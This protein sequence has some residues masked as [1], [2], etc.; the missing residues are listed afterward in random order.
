MNES[1]L[2]QLTLI[3]V[4]AVGGTAIAGR[5]G[6]PSI[7]LLLPLGF[8]F[9]AG[10][11]LLDPDELFGDLLTPLVSLSVAVIL[12]DGGLGLRLARVSAGARRAVVGLL[13]VGVAVTW[14][15]GTLGAMALFDIRR[16]LAIL[17]G[18]ILI[19]SGPTVVLPIL[20]IARPRGRVAAVTRWEGILV[21]PIGAIIAVVTFHVISSGGPN[22]RGEGIKDFA[23]TVGLGVVAG[24]VGATILFKL[25]KFAGLAPHAE[26]GVTLG[27]VLATFAVPD[28]ILED[29][30][31]LSVVI[32]GIFIAN[33][34]RVPVEHI[35]EFKEIVGGLLTGVL[36]IVLSAR[37]PA[38]SLADHLVPALVLTA[39]LVVLARPLAV[40]AA[41]ARTTLAARERAFLA[42]MAPRG[43]VVASVSSI[44]ALQL[45]AQGVPGADDLVPITFIVIVATTALYGLTAR[46]VAVLLGV[47]EPD[48]EPDTTT[49]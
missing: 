49:T 39:I 40:A 1:D 27:I 34:K 33:Q 4:L 18:A 19:M 26:V 35:T 20:S 43:I 15:A 11:G 37:I 28:A 21:D 13:T 38:S 36:F 16:D 7:V 3:V 2:L 8:V 14:L 6:I 24:I 9:G 29:S 30:G 5:F 41:T 22:Y 46:P 10:L 17:M 48:E 45:E 23:L 25:L 31:L 42:W 32:M 44:F 47:A 12:F